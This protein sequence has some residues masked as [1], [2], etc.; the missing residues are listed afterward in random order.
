VPWA[1]KAEGRQGKEESSPYPSLYH[2]AEHDTFEGRT[3]AV[4]GGGYSVGI[5]SVRLSDELAA[6]QAVTASSSLQSHTSLYL[7]IY[8]SAF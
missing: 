4:S 7:S 1:T 3:S 8:L 2:G 5:V 6:R